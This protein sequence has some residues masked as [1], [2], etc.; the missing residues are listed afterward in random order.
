MESKLL[1]SHRHSQ[2]GNKNRDKTAY[3]SFHNQ[4]TSSRPADPLTQNRPAYSDNVPPIF[5]A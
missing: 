2:N 4:V 5:M 3:K 1:R